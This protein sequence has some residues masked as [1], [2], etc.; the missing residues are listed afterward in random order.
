MTTLNFKADIMIAERRVTLNIPIC[1]SVVQRIIEEI[2]SFVN[3]RGAQWHFGVHDPS[4]QQLIEQY[5]RTG[6]L[7]R[8]INA[9]E[10]PSASILS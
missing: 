3:R 4:P 9:V 7:Q 1:S 6:G 8:C 5:I 2:T 10:R